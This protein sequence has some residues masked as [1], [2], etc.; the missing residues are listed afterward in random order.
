MAES[1]LYDKNEQIVTITLNRPEALNAINRQL[2]QEFIDAVLQFDQDDDARVAI[3]TGSGRALL[4][5]A[6]P[7]GAHVRQRRRGS[8]AGQRQFGQ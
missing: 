1:I 7:E 2:K 6:G 5:R 3:V 8:G 4:R